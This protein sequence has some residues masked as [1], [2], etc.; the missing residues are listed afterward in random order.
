[1]KSSKKYIIL[2]GMLALVIFGIGCST[3][4]S[5]LGPVS[6]NTESRA[7]ASFIYPDPTSLPAGFVPLTRSTSINGGRESALDDGNETTVTR[8]IRDIAGGS[9]FLSHSGVTIPRTALPVSELEITVT[10]PTDAYAMV[11]FGPHGTQFESPVTVQLS[12]EGFELP[13]GVTEDDLTIFYIN[14]N[15]EWEMYNGIIH[16]NGLWLTAETD[17][18]SRYIIGCSLSY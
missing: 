14:D 13:E 7:A 18:F 17:H 4:S 15:G 12:M 9:I 11:D 2:I 10:L 8:L 3:D 5:I 16:R 1:M 6:S